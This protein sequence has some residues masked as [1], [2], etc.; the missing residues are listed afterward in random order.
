VTSARI[1]QDR[2][3]DKRLY[4][5][6]VEGLRVL[7]AWLN[8][9]EPGTYRPRHPMLI[10]LYFA[11]RAA[12]DRVAALLARYR[13]DAAARRDRFAARVAEHEA[14]LAA[15]VEGTARRRFQRATAL[16]GVRRAEADLAWL[17]ELPT[18]LSLAPQPSGSGE[19]SA[20]P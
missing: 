7:D 12:P 3:P 13:A 9:P 6:T 4:A 16:F 2:L 20:A 8:E 17:N 11:A 5:P 19:T 18:A 15:G 14:A 1:A 10:K